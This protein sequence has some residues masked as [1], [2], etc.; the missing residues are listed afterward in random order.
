MAVQVKIK[1]PRFVDEQEKQLDRLY[2]Q[3]DKGPGNGKRSHLKILQDVP[4]V[5]N[6]DIWGSDQ[7]IKVFGHD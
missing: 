4:F 1:P 6:S 5:C 2:R 3:S 7:Y